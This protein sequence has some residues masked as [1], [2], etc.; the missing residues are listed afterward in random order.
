LSCSKSFLPAEDHLAGVLA[1]LFSGVQ[2]GLGLFYGPIGVAGVEAEEP[3]EG[4]I[5]PFEFFPI[6]PFQKAVVGEACSAG[7]AAHEVQD[8]R[9][10]PVEEV[11]AGVGAEEELRGLY[12]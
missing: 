6:P 1:Q 11:Q 5:L 8:G 7:E 12:L 9:S 3:A 4:T 2:G 10:S